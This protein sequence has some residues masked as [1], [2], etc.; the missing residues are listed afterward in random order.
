MSSYY[1]HTKNET[2][3]VPYSFQCEHCGKNSGP[4]RAVIKGPE[5][6]E[7]SNFKTLSPNKEER[8]YKRAHENLVR[9]IQRVHKD[10]VEKKIFSKDFHDQC[11]YCR[12]PQSWSVP[13]LKKNMFEYPV[14]CLCVGAFVG[15]LMVAVH[16]MDDTMNITL[17]MAAGVLGLGVV[18]AIACL[19]W[20][21]V[22]FVIIN[23]KTASSVVKNLPVID[24]SP[25]QELLDSTGTGHHTT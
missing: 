15:L 20:N 5:A 13:F 16:Y 2:A 7:N 9:E 23:K 18:A 24:W 6:T 14:I 25:V 11:P 10:A 19:L 22:R 3:E 4:L 8:L 21:V 1:E 12:Q 17:P